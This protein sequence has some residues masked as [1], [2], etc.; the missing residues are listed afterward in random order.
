MIIDHMSNINNTVFNSGRHQHP[1]SDRGARVS[2][3]TCLINLLQSCWFD[4]NNAWQNADTEIV[5][6][7]WTGVEGHDA[8]CC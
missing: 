1:A 7:W 3:C 5:C 4:P 6:Y 2:A 8:L